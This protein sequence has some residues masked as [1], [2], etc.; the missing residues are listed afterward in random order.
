MKKLAAILALGI[1]LLGM[2]P[3]AHSEATNEGS[4]ISMIMYPVVRGTNGLQY[5]INPAGKRI[6]I[7]GLGIAQD[8]TQVA[9][10]RDQQGHFWYSN[11][12]G[13]PTV[14]TRKQLDFVASQLHPQPAATP[15]AP[16]AESPRDSYYAANA[17][18]S[19]GYNGVPYG[20]P[21]NMVAPGQYAYTAAGGNQQAVTPTP[22]SQAQFDQW[23][24]QTPYLSERRANRLGNRSERNS[25]RAADSR[26]DANELMDSGRALAAGRNARQSGRQNRRGNRQDRRADRWGQ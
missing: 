11:I 8:A 3:S 17:T 7:P 25:D 26:D 23:Q 2:A 5:L 18:Y 24:R 9:V 10:Y 4:G 19:A 15:S 21:M 20:T 6:H 22:Q 14:V 1:A 12:D 13:Q 16:P